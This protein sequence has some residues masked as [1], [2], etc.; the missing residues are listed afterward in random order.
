MRNDWARP[1]VAEAVG[2]FALIFSGVLAISAVKVVDAPAG[3]ANLASIG[4]AHGLTI[5]VMVAALGAVSGGHFNPAVTLGFVITGRMSP[6]RGGLYWLAQ[7][8]GAAVAGLLIAALFGPERVAEGTPDLGKGVT[9]AAGVVTEAVTTFF[10][11]LVVFGTAVDE[12]GPKAVTPLAIGLTVAL[13]I[14]AIGPLT[15][16]AMNPAR[17]FGP[18]LASG[19]WAN[20]LVYWIGPLL[21]G[22]LAALVHQFAL[23]ERPSLAAEARGAP[24]GLLQEV[25]VAGQ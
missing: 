25:E 4:L 3:V 5:T 15:G 17:T 16:A 6:A 1:A 8:G 19:H 13:D 9:V 10:L 20:H 14:M 11:V 23:A 22:G 2:T 21:G 7:L 24:A 12:R 18:A